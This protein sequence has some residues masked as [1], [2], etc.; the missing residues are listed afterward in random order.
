MVGTSLFDGNLRALDRLSPPPPNAAALG[1]AFR[2]RR[3]EDLARQLATLDPAARWC[4]AEINTVAQLL[5]SPDLALSRVVFFVS[6]TDDGRDTG[7]VLKSYVQARNDLGLEA[8]DPVMVPQ[9][10]DRRP[11]DFK[12]HGLRNLVRLMGECVHRAG[13]RECV[14]IDA[15]GG[16]KAQIAVAVVLG[17]ALGIPVFY[18]HERFNE[19]IAFPPL[20][21]SLDYTILGAHADILAALERNATLTE[22][23]LRDADPRLLVL[24]N[25]ETVDGVQL[26][27]LN[28]VGQIYLTGFRLSRGHR[29][30]LVPAK[31]RKEPTFGNDH[32]FPPGFKGAVLKLWRENAFIATCHTLPNGRAGRN[33]L[34][35]RVA[36]EKNQPTVVGTYGRD[37]WFPR[38]AVLLEETS[39]DVLT[40][41]AYE[42]NRQY[43][44]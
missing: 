15:T 16:Y 10:Q 35:F 40:L 25:Q 23:D 7:E 21:V 42:L 6:D 3:W 8:D 39:A 37:G 20:P 14:A 43:A 44:E 41:A 32:H 5:Q 22:P 30:R 38:F 29:R 31:D 26:F 34:S 4:G 17:Q 9:L 2:D 1:D 27:E 13:G 18:K 24:L 33:G 12:N 28:A 19:T 36:P 11:K